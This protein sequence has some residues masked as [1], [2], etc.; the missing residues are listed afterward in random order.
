MMQL[1]LPMQLWR[2]DFDSFERFERFMLQ[3]IPAVDQGA[4]EAVLCKQYELLTAVDCSKTGIC[5]LS[6]STAPGTQYGSPSF[7]TSLLKQRYRVYCSSLKNDRNAA[8][9]LQCEICSQQPRR[10]A[11][12]T[13]IQTKWEIEQL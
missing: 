11:I 8:E 5:G 3:S 12:D 6:S 2:H 7:C 1:S 13:G 9:G 4:S 10:A